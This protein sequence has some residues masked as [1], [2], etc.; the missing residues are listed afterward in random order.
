[1]PLSRWSG[2]SIFTATARP[3]KVARKTLQKAPQPTKSGLTTLDQSATGHAATDAA[4]ATGCGWACLDQNAPS[5][6][7]DGRECLR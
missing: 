1:M 5:A 6:C 2:L 3:S 7:P 4:L